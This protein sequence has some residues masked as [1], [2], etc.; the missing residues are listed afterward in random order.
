MQRRRLIAFACAAALLG[1]CKTL[2]PDF[3]TPAAPAAS[4][5]AMSGDA[6]TR[7]AALGQQLAGDWWALFRSPEIDQTVRQA[8][9]GNRSLEAARASLAQARD[10]V[11][12]QAS[13]LTF[14]ANGALDRQRVNLNSFGF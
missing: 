5:Y 2:G 8:V 12:A 13:R 7:E 1:G 10:A 6:P 3:K 14:D 11:Q 4:G 9:A